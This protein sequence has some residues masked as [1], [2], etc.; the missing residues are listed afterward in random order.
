MNAALAYNDIKP[1]MN[2][3]KSSSPTATARA[4]N[5][6][7][8]AEPAG[9][10]ARDLE[11]GA[12]APTP[13][14]LERLLFAIESSQQID[15]RFQFFLWA[16]GVLQSFIPHQTLICAT[17]NLDTEQFE[18]DVFSSDAITQEKQ[19]ELWEAARE[20]TRLAV[21]EW[22]RRGREPLFYS[23]E[24]RE[25]GSDPIQQMIWEMGLGNTLI[26]GTRDIRG[27]NA[28]FYIFGRLA[29]GPRR[30]SREVCEILMPYLHFA[31]H[32]YALQD[33]DAMQ[34]RVPVPE[35]STREI[36]IM[37][38]VRDGKTNMAIGAE[39]GISPLTVKNHVQRILRKLQVNNRA[40]AV[41]RCLVTR[42][43]SGDT[44]SEDA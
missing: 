23:S 39:L 30:R 25:E 32:R 35:L 15:K 21:R 40:Q 37:L 10:Q 12:F 4:A 19:P 42:M 43:F 24:V 17:G 14:E 34:R 13:Q 18:V 27:P 8:G 16:Q 44:L 29:R 22:I 1:A 38:G 31:A 5:E 41:A 11:D 3:R 33:V 28:S 6:S 36:Q 9:A 20:T 2:S 26:H 7:P